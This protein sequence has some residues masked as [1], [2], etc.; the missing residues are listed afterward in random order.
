M[1]RKKRKRVASRG[2]VNNIILRTLVN[3]DKYGYE[4]IKE[5]EEYSDGKIILKQ[6]SLYSSLTRFEEKKFVSSY[7]GDS[8]I[9]GRRHYYHLTEAGLEYYKRVVL[10][11]TD[12]EEDVSEILE[13]NNLELSNQK[14]YSAN[15]DEFDE[16]LEDELDDDTITMSEINNDEIPEIANF[17]ITQPQEQT[18]IV[19][20][21]QF[22]T[23]TPIEQ[24]L[25]DANDLTQTSLNYTN[26]YILQSEVPHTQNLSSSSNITHTQETNES[27]FTNYEAL[28]EEKVNNLRHS[29]KLY[30]KKFA[31]NNFKTLHFH[32]PK[33][34]KKI[35]LDS[36]GIYKLRDEDYVPVKRK[37]EVIIDNV[38]KRHEQSSDI[39]GYASY[40][41]TQKSTNKV[42]NTNNVVETEEE[43][44]QRNENFV[45]K[46][47][48][49]TMS[50][51]KPVSA[52]IPKPEPIEEK[53]P[54]S[55][56]D[57]RGKLNAII[58]NSNVFI[59]DDIEEE[60]NNLTPPINNMFNYVDEDKWNT[61]PQITSPVEQQFEQEIEDE[62]DTQDAFISLDEEETFE[63]KPNNNEYLEEINTYT[64][65]PTPVKMTR[66]DNITQ[67]VLVDKTYL[68]NNKLKL[69]FGI[70]MSIIMIAEVT[71]L[72][73][74][75]KNLELVLSNDKTLFIVAY[76]LIGIFALIYI[77]P[78]FINSNSHKANNF[79]LKYS[80]W[81][82]VLTFLVG[83]ILIYCFNALAGFEI[84]NFNYFAV[85]LIVP[86]T[87]VFNF[88]IGPLVYSLLLKNKNF[89]D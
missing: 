57:Y 77:L 54:T 83:S 33:K 74:V 43:I 17:E 9:G 2:S 34:V 18:N 14:N 28:Y 38:I 40:T 10:K 79:K 27:S 49:L 68:L 63:T 61:S 11:E 50:K 59:E 81:F 29:A 71:A 3:G 55:N 48:L 45:A 4:I 72:L 36:D 82:G 39:L 19:A 41:S 25:E 53:K 86:I 67:A 21:H 32:K 24:M 52:P 35:I 75:F 64:A 23:S 89:Y 16:T 87:L 15:Q 6:P 51:M 60:Q 66:Y 84:D 62:E 37:P 30:N 70:I 56:I 8:D 42:E 12:D 76:V 26:N 69:F 13:E 65:P 73:L 88:I 22:H 80:I 47:N 1:A 7:W 78:F 46:F 31:E 85:K 5:V 44:R 20:D 58:E